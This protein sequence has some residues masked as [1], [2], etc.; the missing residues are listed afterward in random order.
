M[1]KLFFP[2]SV[3]PFTYPWIVKR[4]ITSS[5]SILDIGSGDGKF[6]TH[7]LKNDRTIKLYGVD[8]FDP[9]IKQAKRSKV[10]KKIFK[11]DVRKIKFPERGFDIVLASQIVEH[12]KKN[13]SYSLIKSMERIAKDKVI[14][15]TPNGYFPRGTFENNELQRHHSAWTAEDFRK[16]GYKVYGQSTKFI[17]GKRGLINSKPAKN[18]LVR[19]ILFIISYILS[20]I[21]Y[22]LPQYSAHLIA[23]KK[24]KIN[25]FSKF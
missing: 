24:I 14:I 16:L 15:G 5:S 2:P 25:I 12:L 13:D 11:Q 23:V 17:Y 20:P 9:Y 3:I 10:Y 21:T 6:M 18:L 8:L 1:I 7:I 22:F 4:N 19:S